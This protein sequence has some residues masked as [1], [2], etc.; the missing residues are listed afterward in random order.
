VADVRWLAP[1]WLRVDLAD[2]PDRYAPWM[3]GVLAVAT[4]AASRLPEAAALGL[5]S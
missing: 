1:D 3:G 4:E 5:I 2:N